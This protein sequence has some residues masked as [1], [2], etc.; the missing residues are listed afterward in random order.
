MRIY[1][2]LVP[3]IIRTQIRNLQYIYDDIIFI[4]RYLKS[5]II[6]SNDLT[7]NILDKSICYII[8]ATKITGGVAVVCEH[9]NRLKKLGYKT[10]IVSCD[11]KTDL[12]WFPN[13][14]VKVVPLKGNQKL[15]E[16]YE[17]VVATGWIT[18]YELLLIKVR[19][20][21]Y[22][23]Q[24]DE[25]RFYPI[26]SYLKTRVKRTYTFPFKFITIAKWLQK[27]LKNNFNQDSYYIPNG[28]NTNIFY[29][30]TLLTPKPKNKKRILLEGAINLPFKGMEQAFK[31]VQDCD[32]EV[33]CV[34]Y[35]GRPKPEWHCDRF[36]EKVPMQEMRH[37]YSSCDIMLKLSRVEGFFGPPLEMMAC[38]GVPIV[39]QVTGCEEYI[40]DGYNALLTEFSNVKKTKQLLNKLI[41]N[42]KLYNYLQTNSYKTVQAM[43][44]DKTITRLQKII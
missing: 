20:K 32:C 25:T 15:I 7:K 23:V 24:S 21:M 9:L 40:K 43:N 17:T 41:S 6:N 31:I 3:E 29:P 44:W 4:F 38:G 39:A 22:L 26:G 16:R 36:F 27:F 28:I 5:K 33:W 2:Q 34:S 37:I 14:S 35:D 12:S 10:L 19:R 8:P 11:N 1:R 18:A 42:Q 30:D 13:Q